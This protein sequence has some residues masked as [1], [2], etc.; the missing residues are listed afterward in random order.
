MVRSAVVSDD[1]RNL[2]NLPNVWR[3]RK[4]KDEDDRPMAA[5]KM[6]CFQWSKTIKTE[7]DKMKFITIFL[8]P[9]SV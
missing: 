5:F 3:E 1:A 8:V 9:L 2:A 7:S 6:A 4:V